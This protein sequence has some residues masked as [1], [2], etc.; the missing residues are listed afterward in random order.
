MGTRILLAVLILKFFVPDS[1]LASAEK[2]QGKIFIT[3]AIEFFFI[4]NANDSVLFYA[5][6]T[7]A[8]KPEKSVFLLCKIIQAGAIC[9]NGHYD[10]AFHLMEKINVSGISDNRMLSWY[11][12]VK[13]LVLFRINDYAGSWQNLSEAI[14]MDKGGN[15]CFPGFCKRLQA[16]I[17]ISRGD[18]AEGIN[19][20]NQSSTHYKNAG[21]LKSWYINEKMIGRYYMLLKDWPKALE[22]FTV[23][24]RGL[25]EF[26]DFAEVFYV[27]VNL[28]DYYLNTNNLKIARQYTDSTIMLGSKYGTNGML[29]LSNMNMGEI[30]LKLK[31]YQEA[32]ES[33]QKS[34]L[35]YQRDQDLR[36]SV[37]AYLDLGKAYQELNQKFQSI[38]YL[39]SALQLAKS[40]KRKELL[41]RSYSALAEMQ[42]R[43]NM[44]DSAFVN[45]NRALTYKDSLFRD[46]TSF[47][48]AFYEVKL[49]LVQKQ[50]EINL[51][52]VESKRQKILLVSGSVVILLI[53]VSSVLVFKSL[54]TKNQA[55]K[56]LVQKNLQLIHEKPLDALSIPQRASGSKSS[57]RNND[58]LFYT[59]TQWLEQNNKFTEK[60]ITIE[61]AAKE[62]GTNREYLSQ[63]I[64]EK[65]GRYTD[66]INHYRIKSAMSQISTN[67]NLKLS[68]IAS[69]TGFSSNSSFIEAF[70]KQTGMT[71]AQF[72]EN[73]P[74][75]YQK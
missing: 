20:F 30:D 9:E 31:N 75:E 3:K 56:A 72:R 55:L 51:L 52:R 11:Y 5:S 71:P 2:E 61:M 68:Y 10:S 16:R 57:S 66:L 18:Y 23:S 14:S 34:L 44:P 43:F 62:L 36:G 15:E 39:D 12:C 27:Y 70:K 26:S 42:M 1:C 38:H 58:Q 37:V 25:K 17:C 45:L 32:I 46:E 33:F 28:A 59:F 47:S 8:G 63:A 22:H 48:K 49:G 13:G 41:R 65:F 73:L 7:L 35:Y 50:N 54:R 69:M 40:T 60:N 19:L 21:Q 74:A 24:L 6:K 67:P 4:E 64:N 53:V 29:A